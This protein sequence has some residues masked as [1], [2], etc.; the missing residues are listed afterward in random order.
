MNLVVIGKESLVQGKRPRKGLIE[1]NDE[2]GTHQID[3]SKC[4]L[5]SGY[6]HLALLTGEAHEII[7]APPPRRLTFI[8]Q[9]NRRRAALHLGRWIIW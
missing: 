4:E 1:R 8:Y 9:L 7:L 2:D 3:V 5:R 6:N